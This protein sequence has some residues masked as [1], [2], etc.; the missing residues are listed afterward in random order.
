[1]T[2][3]AAP[4]AIPA[5][6][7]L[8]RPV[9]LLLSPLEEVAVAG[10]V[11]VVEAAEAAATVAVVVM[12]DCGGTL[13]GLKV[14]VSDVDAVLAALDTT[15]FGCKSWYGAQSGLGAAKGHSS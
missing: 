12:M 10:A 4:T 7:P 11:E 14:A 1:M 3:A 15:P 8:V 2:P 6:A 9:W 13:E 5:M